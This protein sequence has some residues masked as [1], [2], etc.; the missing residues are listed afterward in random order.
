MNPYAVLLPLGLAL[1]VLPAG[2]QTPRADSLRHVLRTGSLPD[3]G[4]L[5]GLLALARELS[6]SDA[7]QAARLNQQAL[8]LAQRLADPVGEGQALLGLSILSRRQSDYAL[9]RRYAQQAKQLFSRLGDRRGLGKAWQQIS[10]IDMLQ[11]NPTPALAAA[12][13]GLAL[14]EATGDLQTRSRLLAAIGTIYFTM[15]S[16]GEALPKLQAALTAG[17]RAGDQALVLSALDGLGNSYQGLKKWPQAVVYYQRAL[18]LSQQLG[19]RQSETGEETGLAEVYGMQGNRAEALAHGLRA[20]Q[21]V[22]ASHDSY[23]LPSVELMLARAYLLAHQTDSALV[24]AHRGLVLSQQTRSNHAI[25]TAS[26]ILAQAYAERRDFHQAYRYRTLHLAYN[27]TLSGEETRRQT[28]TLRYGY[29]LDKKQAQIALLT[30]TR[31]LRDQETAHR[32]TI[33]RQ[34]SYALL[35]GLLGAGVVAGLLGRNGYLK[36]RA[37]RALNEKNAHIARQ[38]D[39]LDRALTALQAAQRQ[40]IQSEK[41]VALAALTAGVA[42]EIQNPLNFVNNFSEVSAELCQ[43]AQELLAAD[44]W[45]PADKAKL[46]DLLA[47]L[48]QNQAKISQHGQ[49]A[50]GIVKGMLEHSQTRT[51]ERQPTDLNRLCEEYLRSAYQGLRAKDKSFSA[52]LSTD[53]AADVPLVNAV[54]GDLGRVLLNLFANAFYAVRQR[55]QAGEPGYQPRVG[56]RTQV[57]GQQVQL[58]VTDNGTGMSA[59]VQDKIFQ[60]FFTTKPPGEGTGLGLSLAHDI[61]AQGHGG[62]LAVESRE[63]QGTTFSV[64]L[65][66]NGAALLPS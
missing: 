58:Q 62:T 15:G 49:R 34:Q 19:D 11:G 50:A 56:V 22:M 26:D 51:G 13:K 65:P 27:D 41:L 9:A 29:E 46:T 3:S 28:S 55:Q 66:A 1:S 36:Q 10:A 24:L 32:E 47:D 35:A 52:E 42:H 39:D 14:A 21:L 23:S 61:I 53:L 40:L 37:N 43:E 44:E 48:G 12:L 6:A 60:P 17:Q 20:R 64:E 2:A 7:P 63:G 8:G 33:H 45:T 18:Q 30:K 5:H 59:G 57:L 38:R 16:Y 4:R 54:G 31:Q 25:R